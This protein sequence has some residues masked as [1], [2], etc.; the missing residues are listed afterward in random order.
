[1]AE[2]KGI[3][4]SKH[5]YKIDWKKV[6]ADGIKFAIIRAGY[7]RTTKDSYVDANANGCIE[8]GIAIGFYWFLY[9]TNV[10][11]AEKNAEMF[12]SV[13]SKY[14]DKITMKVWCDFEYDTDK[15]ANQK[16]VTFTKATRT[17][18][19]NAFCKK[20]ESYG[21]EVGNY[22]NQ[23]Y[24]NNKF[25]KIDYPLWFAKYSSTKGS[26]DCVMWQY[27]SKGSV[28]GINGNVDMNIYYDNTVK[29]KMPTL[30]K[31]AKGDSVKIL[32]Y[33]LNKKG[34][35]LVVD[36]SFGSKTESAV[37]DYQSKNKDLTGKPL[38]VDGSVG[39]KTW[40]SLGY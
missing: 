37:K 34:S 4:V 3:D 11:E 17:A 7:G 21:Y 8:N 14:K 22:A 24:L 28:A 10:A 12:H 16:G 27:S 30:K 38:A 32:Q 26:R 33:E 5:Q 1:M 2:I 29:V 20:M 40:G 39:Q 35:N 31:G 6:K 36:G 23:D 18:C 25:D 15:N 19:V 9:C 13:I